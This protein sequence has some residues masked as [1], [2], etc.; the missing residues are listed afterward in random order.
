MGVCGGECSGEAGSRGAS[1]AGANV[2]EG[3]EILRHEM[4]DGTADES[5]RS[6]L[7]GLA[8]RRG[9][10]RLRDCA[11]ARPGDED[12][13]SGLAPC[14][15]VPTL[16]VPQ[17]PPSSISLSHHQ[18]MLLVLAAPSYWGRLMPPWPCRPTAVMVLI[19]SRE[20]SVHVA[21]R[22]AVGTPFFMG[23]VLDS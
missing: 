1:V 16:L 21:N 2:A 12:A 9:H 22:H 3:V 23:D 5:T 19:L 13:A 8:Q 15:S 17:E 6:L 4:P 7:S 11:T 18:V 10:V 14:L 20:D